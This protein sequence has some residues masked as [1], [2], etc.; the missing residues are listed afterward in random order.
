MIDILKQLKEVDLAA[1]NA[2]AEH[3]V[4]SFKGTIPPSPTKNQVILKFQ[5][6]IY[7]QHQRNF[8]LAIVYYCIDA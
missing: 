8:L 4:F 6:Y 5:K 3:F 2:Y 1:Q 7:S